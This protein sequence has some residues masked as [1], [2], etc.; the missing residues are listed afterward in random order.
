PGSEGY[1]ESIA[2]NGSQRFTRVNVTAAKRLLADAEVTKP[3][4]C[5]LFDPANPR[6]VREFE[7]IQ[8]SAA[9]AGF[10]VTNCSSPDW[11]DFLGVDGAYDAALFAWNETTA[12]V[13]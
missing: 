7:L 9:E 13:S 11:E 8:S 4:V 2:S 1:D 3:V 10:R 5:I 6:R 12:A